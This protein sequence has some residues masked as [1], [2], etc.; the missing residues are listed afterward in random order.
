MFVPGIA[1][2]L[3]NFLRLGKG[4]I[5]AWLADLKI[6]WKTSPDQKWMGPRSRLHLATL[7]GIYLLSLGDGGRQWRE[8]LVLYEQAHFGR[9]GLGE[10]KGLGSL[11]Q[12]PTLAPSSL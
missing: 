4:S 11:A 6:R 2:G 10:E 7:Q 3:D 9:Q 8:T 5:S 1:L 12:L